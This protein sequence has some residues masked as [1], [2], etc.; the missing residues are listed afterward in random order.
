M[1]DTKFRERV[2]EG[3]LFLLFHSGQKLPFQCF[4]IHL[5]MQTIGKKLSSIMLC[6]SNYCQSKGTIYW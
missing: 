3:R 5:G 6:L 2:I 4:S 1:F